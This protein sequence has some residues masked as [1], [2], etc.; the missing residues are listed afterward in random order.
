MAHLSQ[1]PEAP[2]RVLPD[3]PLALDAVVLRALGKRPD[4]RFQT[5]AELHAALSKLELDASL[6]TPPGALEATQAPDAIAET[7]ALT[8]AR[9]AARVRGNLPH[10]ISSFVG[11]T[12][13]IDEVSALLRG[14]RVLTLTGIGGIG[15]TRLALRVA[16]TVGDEF[17]DGVWLVELAALDDP[18]L[19]ADAVAR[20]LGLPGQ[21]G[22][23][24]HDSL[25]DFLRPKQ[26]LL[27]L[28]NCE[29]LVEACAELAESLLLDAPRLKVLATSREALGLAGETVWQV[30]ALSVTSRAEGTVAE[31]GTPRD[32]TALTSEAVR[33]FADRATQARAGF[34]LTAAIEPVVAAICARLDGIPLAIELA[35][36]RVKV[37]APEQIL[38][39]LDDRFRLL[40]SGPRSALRRQHA[41]RATFDWSHQLL[42]P[43]EQRL[44]ARLSVF[45]GDFSLESAEEICAPDGEPHE[46]SV[47]DLLAQ[48]ADKS[49]VQ[50][51][52]DGTEARYRMLETTREYAAEKL[53]ERGETER[54]VTAHRDW[55]LALAERLTERAGAHL[56]DPSCVRLAAEHD[57]LRA[58]LHGSLKRLEDPEPALRLCTALGPF[59]YLR[60]HWTEGRRALEAA[61]AAGTAVDPNWRAE[62]LHWAGILA[63]E[64]GDFERARELLDESL[65]LRRGCAD[66]RALAT[67]LQALGH[68]SERMGDYDRAG[69]L[70]RESLDRMRAL[71]DP[72]GLMR[73]TNGMGLRALFR[74]AFDEARELFLEAHAISRRIEDQPNVG[75]VLHNLGEAELKRGDL[76]AAERHLTESITIARAISARRI[77][78]YS[79]NLLGLAATLR[80]DVT[81]AHRLFH[82]ALVFVR[83]EGDKDG[84]AYAF[85]G[86]AGAQASQGRFT[87]VMRLTGAA[88][89]LRETIRSMLPPHD[90]RA[91]A[92]LARAA[93]AALGPEVAAQALDEGRRMSL[94]EAI[95]YALELSGDP[96]A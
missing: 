9:V 16:G 28:D 42:S 38:A 59:W 30:P 78:A 45:A 21:A 4:D 46:A 43:P 33:L 37:L 26:A 55:F 69:E 7:H 1:L 89:V 70:K 57:N 40:G 54:F 79:S 83:D 86:L 47:L 2:S 84:I 91:F 82:E 65:S 94:A 58:A 12:R 14:A 11:R 63:E 73:A 93:R 5:A 8:P 32:G 24:P 52:T 85:E 29:H 68:V 53:T 60:T 80:G 87:E 77:V 92:E 75:V 64:Q 18:T 13:E 48:L 10:P 74:G 15:K 95:G 71:D 44:F 25:S 27:V 76:D 72:R 96:P 41:L 39:K 50:V 6:A 51:D 34:Q 20:A 49:L 35:A 23:P 17:Q 3:L 61:L 31:R 88:T 67:T 56:S 36:A 81:R 66:E 62:A 90:E 22:P 19:V